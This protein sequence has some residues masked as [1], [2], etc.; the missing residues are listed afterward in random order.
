MTA[1]AAIPTRRP[2]CLVAW[3]VCPVGRVEGSCGPPCETMGVRAVGPSLKTVFN[4]DGFYPDPQETVFNQLGVAVVQ[5]DNWPSSLSPTFAALGAFPLVVGSKD[6]ALLAS[7]NGPNTAQISGVGPGVLLVEVYDADTVVTSRLTNVSARNQIGTGADILIS[8]FVIDG[9][10]AKTLL[11][12]GIGPALK[13]VF[14]VVGAITDPVLEIHQTVNGQD[15]ILARNDNW[16]PNLAPTF[17]QVG[18]Y[19]FVTNSKDSALLLTLPPGVYTAQVSGV[20]SV[21]GDG[22][23]EVYELP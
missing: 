5:N 1:P 19:S 18:A 23:V 10:V 14:G 13:D 22:V 9:P 6:A 12:R 20:N 3:R 4:L 21:T 16:E 17:A 7:I 11:I 2:W 15:T 8:G